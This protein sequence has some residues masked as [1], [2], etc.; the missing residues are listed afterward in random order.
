[1]EIQDFTAALSVMSVIVTPILAFYTA[2]RASSGQ[3]R[4]SEASEIWEEGRAIRQD[5][6][7]DNRRL[8]DKLDKIEEEMKSLREEN[9]NLQGQIYDLRR[10]NHN[11]RNEIQT[12][13]LTEK[14][15]QEDKERILSIAK[16]EKVEPR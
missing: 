10:L 5:L 11:M 14:I 13:F 9:D 1:M 7:E 2:K 16:G 4:T 3:V 15:T 12:W 6:R 8:E